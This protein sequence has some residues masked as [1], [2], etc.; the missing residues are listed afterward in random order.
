VFRRLRCGRGAGQKRRRQSASSRTIRLAG[1]R[2]PAHSAA[3][4]ANPLTAM[5][6]GF[7]RDIGIEVRDANLPEPT[8]LPGLD[9]RFGALLVDEERLLYPGDVLHEAGHIAVAS[10]EERS[11]ET[12]KPRG[13]DEIAA[14]AWSYAA[15]RRLE[16]DPAIVFHEAGYRGSAS[17]SSRI[18][19]P[20]ASSARRSYSGTA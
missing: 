19:R 11:R 6:T 3:M 16:I 14:I 12:L 18:S 17:A 1:G 4:F 8:F 20:G 2:T 9:I 13:G 15:A 5:L 10:P 7:V